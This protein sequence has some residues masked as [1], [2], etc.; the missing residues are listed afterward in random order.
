M[1][2]FYGFYYVNDGLLAGMM[3]WGKFR[4]NRTDKTNVVV[5]SVGL[6]GARIL[7]DKAVCA[8]GKAAEGRR[9]RRRVAWF[10]R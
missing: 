10:G 9:N 2:L 8:P 4:T 1:V 6:M 5:L 7:A 3:G